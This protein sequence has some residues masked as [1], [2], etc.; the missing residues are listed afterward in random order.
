[1]HSPESGNRAAKRKIRL[2]KFL[3]QSGTQAIN[4][5][6]MDNDIMKENFKSARASRMGHNVTD[7][8]IKDIN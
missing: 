3:C 2:E 4:Q 1:M 8:H 6:E 7:I 5:N